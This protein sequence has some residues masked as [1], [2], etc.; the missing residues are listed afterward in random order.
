MAAAAPDVT[1]MA[2]VATT[3]H[4][5]PMATAS[6]GMSRAESLLRMSP[7]AAPPPNLMRGR[8]T[9]RLRSE[10][11]RRHSG[12]I[13]LGGGENGEG[14]DEDWGSEAGSFRGYDQTDVRTHCR[15]RRARARGGS[16]RAAER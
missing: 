1:V 6:P 9:V 13:P 10:T 11:L 16:A 12:A 3:P 5:S 15:R 2:A 7:G 4:I 14:D 8:S